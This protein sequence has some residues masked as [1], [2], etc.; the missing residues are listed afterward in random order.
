MSL[1]TCQKR[2]PRSLRTLETENGP[3]TTIISCNPTQASYV[4]PLLLILR[5]T[6][7]AI[8]KLCCILLSRCLVHR[9][10]PAAPA[11]DGVRKRRGRSTT[12]HRERYHQSILAAGCVA[13]EDK[14]CSGVIETE[15]AGGLKDPELLL[16][17]KEMTPE[18]TWWQPCGL[19]HVAQQCGC[20]PAVTTFTLALGNEHGLNHWRPPNFNTSA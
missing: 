11:S 10:V 19:P 20:A 6:F 16:I 13:G 5:S 4:S 14:Q 15:Q 9:G 17:D 1:L 7:H 8:P 3:A 18:S 12:Q 2:S